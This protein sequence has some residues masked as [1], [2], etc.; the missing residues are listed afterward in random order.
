VDQ[1]F[2]VKVLIPK[3]EEFPRTNNDLYLTGQ[4]NTAKI[5][6]HRAWSGIYGYGYFLATPTVPER[7]CEN[8]GNP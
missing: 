5:L 6:S 8:V 2:K 7:F 4:S 1:T 3:Q